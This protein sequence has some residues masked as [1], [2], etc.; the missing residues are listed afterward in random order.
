M[1]DIEMTAPTSVFQQTETSGKDTVLSGYCEAAVSEG[2][3]RCI[4]ICFSSNGRTLAKDINIEIG[5]ASGGALRFRL[6]SLAYKYGWWKRFSIYSAVGV[7]EVQVRGCNG[8]M[9][10][11]LTMLNADHLPQ[12]SKAKGPRCAS[13]AC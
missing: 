5:N 8:Y 1:A 11:M 10:L 2:R 4:W 6:G 12:W 13:S 3:E 7:K 9:L